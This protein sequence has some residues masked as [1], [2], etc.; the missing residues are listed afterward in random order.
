MP[1]IITHAIVA[2]VATKSFSKD[3]MSLRLWSLAVLC[4]VVP[5]ADIIGF[6]F[7]IRYE[8]IIGHRGFF[9]SIFFSLILS[10]FLCLIFFRQLNLF[11]KQWLKYALFLF[12]V[13][14]SHGILDAFTNGGLGIAL[15]SPIDNTRFFSPWTP[16]AVSPI[17][18]KS[19]LS[20]R[21]LNVIISEIIFIWLP[22]I[23]FLVVLKIKKSAIEKVQLQKKSISSL[24]RG[25]KK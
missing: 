8:D 1:S 3:R 24:N 13:G 11:S 16:I 25:D 9:H 10:I 23:T 12:A 19:F 7:G 4:S 5:D 14:A 21:G 22:L 17:R 15:L 6:V 18:L 20:I 2:S